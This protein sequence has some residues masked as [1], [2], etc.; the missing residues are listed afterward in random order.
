M[1]SNPDLPK[2]ATV[3]MLAHAT[4]YDGVQ[5]YGFDMSACGYVNLGPV[6]IT[7]DVPQVDVVAAQISGLEKTKADIVKEYEIK[8]REINEQI[9]N[10]RAL[11][12]PA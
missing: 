8:L 1:T 6:E 7:F 10:L 4:P 9:Q 12:A 5:L 3:T 2:T 11:S